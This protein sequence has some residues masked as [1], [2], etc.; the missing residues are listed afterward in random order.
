MSRTEEEAE[1]DELEEAKQPES[2]G[3]ERRF[4]IR[5]LESESSSSLAQGPT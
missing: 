5:R 2:R 4:S 3:K 1:A